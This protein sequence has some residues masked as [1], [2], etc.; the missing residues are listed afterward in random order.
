[1]VSFDAIRSQ[2]KLELAAKP[3]GLTYD[4]LNEIIQ[5]FRRVASDD[6]HLFMRFDFWMKH[7]NHSEQIIS[8]NVELVRFGVLAARPVRQTSKGNSAAPMPPSFA[9]PRDV[10]RFL[11]RIY[12]EPKSVSRRAD[13]VEARAPFL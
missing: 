12:V 7:K 5:L 10:N 11:Q 1:M 2:F 4:E 3:R 9:D 13:T 6:E 8:A